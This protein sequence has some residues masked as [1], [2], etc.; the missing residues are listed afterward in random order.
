MENCPEW[1]MQER[2]L[3]EGYN[4]QNQLHNKDRK[5]VRLGRKDTT[6]IM[7][8]WTTTTGSTTAGH[9]MLTFAART[10]VSV[11][12]CYSN[13]QPQRLSGLGDSG[14]FFTP[15][16]CLQWWA[17]ASRGLMLPWSQNLEKGKA[18]QSNSS[19]SF[20]LKYNI[21]YFL[22][23]LTDKSLIFYRMGKCNST[24]H[25]KWEFLYLWSALM[26]LPVPIQV[27]PWMLAH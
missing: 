8:D 17:Q 24:K 16:I 22:S 20:F 14:S 4:L 26:T 3:L 5:E 25:P 2:D 10:T 7:A 15:I 21:D 6:K 11:R 9:W 13:K 18:S 19:Y 27:F 23:G 12:L 1:F